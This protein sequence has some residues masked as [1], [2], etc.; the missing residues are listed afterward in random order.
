MLAILVCLCAMMVLGTRLVVKGIEYFIFGLTAKGKLTAAALVLVMATSLPELFVAMAAVSLGHVELSLSNLLGANVADLS[1]VIGGVAL[2]VGS[3]PVVGDYWRWDLAATFLAGVAPILLM[4]DGSLSRIDGLILLTIYL[5]YIEGL[6]IDGKRKNL[7]KMGIEGPGII[8]QLTHRFEKKAGVS[9]FGFVIGITLLSL[10]AYGLVKISERFGVNTLTP[11]V[12]GL[13]VVSLVTTL[14]EYMEVFSGAIRRNTALILSNLLG[15]VVTNS[16]LLIGLLALI[17]PIKT[18]DVTN[19]SIA[20]LSF[21]V[22]FGLFWMFTSTKRKLDRW[23]ALI[24]VGIYVTFIGL[25]L[26]KPSF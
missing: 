9:L 15:S 13:I 2:M 3:V 22:I 10:G 17:H 11:T 19:Y 23:E 5:L 24:L 8:S 26:L 21:V 1:L 6:V 25:L 12:F 20:N 18:L 4:M 16:T 14:P 7:A